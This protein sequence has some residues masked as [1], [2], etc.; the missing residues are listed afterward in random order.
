MNETDVRYT[1]LITLV[2]GLFHA[3]LFFWGSHLLATHAHGFEALV[4]KSDQNEYVSIAH[5][6]LNTGRFAL[7]PE[8]PP[9][10]F[11][12]PGYPAML[13]FFFALFPHTFSFPYLFQALM[14]GVT[15]GAVFLLARRIYLSRI[16]ALG[17]AA[18]FTVSS[19][20]ILLTL[21]GTGSD[22]IYTTLQAV[23]VCVLAYAAITQRHYVA[24][25]LAGALLGLATLVRPIGIVASLPIIMLSGLFAPALNTKWY[26]KA[27]AVALVAFVAVLSPWYVRNFMLTGHAF[28]STVPEYNVV[29]YNIPYFLVHKEGISE[30]EARTRTLAP[31]GTEEPYELREY[32]ND[33]QLKSIE[34]EFI[35]THLFSYA[36]FHAYKS[37][38][39][40]MGS[41]FN[42]I[43]AVYVKESPTLKSSLFPTA[44][45]NLSEAIRTK[46]WALALKNVRS[47]WFTTLERLLWLCAIGG[48]LLAP[49][50]AFLYARRF[51][52]RLALLV[53]GAAIVVTTMA[54]TSPVTQPRYR[55]PAEPFIW[56][57]A[58]SFLHILIM[59]YQAFLKRLFVHKASGMPTEFVRHFVV[60]L[61]ALAIDFGVMA[62]LTYEGFDPVLAASLGFTTGL[63]IAYLGSRHWVFEG[64]SAFKTPKTMALFACIGLGG[65]VLNDGIIAALVYGAGMSAM[66]SKAF[67][68]PVTFLWNFFARRY[69]L[70][71]A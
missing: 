44:S 52:T 40:L 8:S 24:I 28:F 54:I 3:A 51:N 17:A 13:A 61:L 62:L 22:V 65:L 70:F 48:A 36:V 31:F 55:V 5:T 18:L 46:N 35:Q 64:E 43:N 20:P 27:V 56:I 50:A 42:V 25:A 38:P 29:Y 39:F 1:A 58:V 69:L 33:T 49:C 7:S 45:E 2:A 6:W 57:G 23:A 66:A 12:T 14:T 16:W 34:K 41:G 67:S 30:A 32:K 26:A 9:E 19:G 71:T 15:A 4:S 10:V 68:V 59:Q 63:A 53:L 60:S 47:Y 37:I 11:R 21:T